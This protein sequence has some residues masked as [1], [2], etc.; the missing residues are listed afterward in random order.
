MNQS[1]KSCPRRDAVYADAKG[2]AEKMEE[3][4]R[5]SPSLFPLD[6]IIKW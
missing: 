4:E 1:V 5:G 2:K 3:N 6:V